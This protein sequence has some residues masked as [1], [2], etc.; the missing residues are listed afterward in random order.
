MR[1]YFVKF[2]NN[3]LHHEPDMVQEAGIYIFVIVLI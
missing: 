2:S 3:S 1:N